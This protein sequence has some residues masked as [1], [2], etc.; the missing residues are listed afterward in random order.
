MSEEVKAFLAMLGSG[1]M[2]CYVIGTVLLN[3]MR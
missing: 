1:A 2:F 3:A